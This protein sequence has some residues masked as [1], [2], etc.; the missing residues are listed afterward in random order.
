MQWRLVSRF[1]LITAACNA[2]RKQ[3]KS[4]AR[5]IAP[6]VGFFLAVVT[7]HD[8]IA[9]LGIREERK[10]GLLSARAWACEKFKRQQFTLCRTRIATAEREKLKLIYVA[11]LLHLIS[12]Q[13]VI[14]H[15]SRY[16]PDRGSLRATNTSNFALLPCDLNL[17]SFALAALAIEKKER[18]SNHS[19]SQFT[20]NPM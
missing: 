19:W 8:E 20:C 4:R 15:L 7:V 3:D 9:A 5:R 12:D 6:F 18:K 11:L 1:T 10:K 16:R 14:F 2:L 13:S 17:S